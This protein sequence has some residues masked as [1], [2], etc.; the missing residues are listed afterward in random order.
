MVDEA[1]DI[2]N[3]SSSNITDFG[4][5]L[6]ETWMIKRKLTTRITTEKIDTLYNKAMSAGAIGGKLL[7]A[8]GGGFIL[9]FVEPDKQAKVMKEMKNLLYVP[10]KETR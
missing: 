7:G 5:L 10:F 2:L 4:K 9:F 6:N 1:I 8:G 3:G